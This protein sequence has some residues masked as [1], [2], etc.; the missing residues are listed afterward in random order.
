MYDQREI[1]NLF[2]W[3]CDVKFKLSKLEVKHANKR[4]SESELL[5]IRSIVKRL[6]NQEPIQYI[7]GETTF[8]DCLIKVN[9][10]VLIPRPETEELVAWILEDIEGK[11]R[12]LDIGTGSGCI[13]IAFK[14]NVKVADVYALDVSKE[15]LETAKVSA[16]L[17]ETH[18][19]FIQKDIL[20]ENLS[21]LPRFNVI[22]SN[23]PYVLESDKKLMR[24]NVLDNEPHLALFVA[25]DDP[26]LFYNR[27]AQIAKASLV[28]DGCLYF[29]IHENLSA[30]VAKMLAEKGY[31]DI[32]VRQDLQGKDRMIKCIKNN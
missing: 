19:Q 8:Y 30:E 10:S 11:I 5:A 18:I 17:N 20:A 13:P 26:L 4:L 31:R 15:A 2:Y 12:L 28:K 3:V 6:V 29:E 21:E 23:P 24:A 1:D 25:D 32:E 14:N 27:I 9:P 16:E 22:V 7:L